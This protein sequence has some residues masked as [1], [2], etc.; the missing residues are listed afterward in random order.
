[1]HDAQNRHPIFMCPVSGIVQIRVGRTRSS[2]MAQASTTRATLGRTYRA[3]G[4]RAIAMP[5]GGLA[6]GQV[7]LGGDG[8]LRQWQLF[9]QSNHLAFVPDSFFAIRTSDS[10]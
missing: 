6:T 5:L 1:M 7:A 4:V 9:N 3:E 8:G 10:P 2:T